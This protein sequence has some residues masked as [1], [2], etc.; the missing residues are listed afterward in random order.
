MR[1]RASTV[2]I[3]AAAAP[4]NSA[5]PKSANTPVDP[6]CCST[7]PTDGGS[8]IVV[9]VATAE[10]E[11]CHHA[12]HPRADRRRLARS[13]D[14]R[15][16]ARSAPPE[17]W[18]HIGEVLH[19]FADGLDR[20]DPI[21]FGA[22]FTADGVFDYKARH[23]HPRSGGSRRGRGRIFAGVARSSHQVGPPVV[24]P[25]DRLEGV[26]VKILFSAS[27]AQDRQAADAARPL[28][29]YVC[30]GRRGWHPA[31]RLS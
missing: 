31:G 25:G 5:T 14:R 10:A 16:P 9:T 30:T 15:V 22:V 13:T 21:A 6:K 1:L 18:Q 7:R 20:C 8:T 2:P 27:S 24:T 11:I 12:C 29:G 4:N 3:L 19:D 17:V 28:R 23:H 26:A